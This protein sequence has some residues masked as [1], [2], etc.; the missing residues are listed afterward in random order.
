[1]LVGLADH[2][3]T[4]ASEGGTRRLG[5]HQGKWE[6]KVLYF[7]IAHIYDNVLNPW[8]WTE[9]MRSRAL[10]N[11]FE[12]SSGLSVLD[13]GAGTGFTSLGVLEQGVSPSALIMLDQSPQQLEQ[14]RSKRAL[15]GVEKRLGD[16][17]ALPQEWSGKFDRYVSA[18]SIEYWPH[19]QIAIDEA[20][21]VIKTGGK[22]MIIGPVR[23][24]NVISRFFADTWYLFPDKEEYVTW[25]TKAGFTNI[26]IA[27]ICPRWYNGDRS[28]GLIMGF[29]VTGTKPSA[30]TQ[31]KRAPA[32]DQTPTDDWISVLRAGPRMVLG[33]VGGV[34]YAFLPLAVFAVNV[35][36]GGSWLVALGLALVPPLFFVLGKQIC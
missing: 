9:E 31:P 13:V 35:W 29:S 24:T 10:S 28:H 33:L 23:P 20:A 2:F 12:L 15:D 22:A 30:W 26:S 25:F 8:H 17:E 6:A 27:E 16:A 19:P 34:Y 4:A 1:L 36:F 3:L 18:G 21:R 32:V 11:A 5:S 7:F 14:A